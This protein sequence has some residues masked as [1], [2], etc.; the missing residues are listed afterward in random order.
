MTKSD[1]APW[2]VQPN[3]VDEMLSACRAQEIWEYE[4]NQKTPLNW[5]I[6]LSHKFVENLCTRLIIAE[7]YAE[8]N[9]KK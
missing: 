3:T 7:L 5:C 6:R 2:N 8:V 9:D 4:N 1:K